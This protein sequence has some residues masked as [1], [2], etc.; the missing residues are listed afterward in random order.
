MREQQQITTSLENV[1]GDGERRK[2]K[3]KKKGKKRKSEKQH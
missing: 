2:K 1:K 3:K